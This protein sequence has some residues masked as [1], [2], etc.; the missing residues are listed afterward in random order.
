MLLEA[1]QLARRGGSDAVQ[2]KEVA[3]RAGVA[4][5]TLYRHFPS[6]KELLVA[7][8]QERNERMMDRVRSGPPVG[9]TPG[10]RVAHVLEAEF[11]GI[12]RQHKLVEAMLEAFN[13]ADRS[14]GGIVSANRRLRE[15]IMIHAATGG[16]GELTR[17]QLLVL[18]TILGAWSFDITA[19]MAGLR[20]GDD[21]LEQMQTACRML[22]LAGELDGARS[23]GTL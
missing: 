19:W 4:L 17:T 12:E 9:D 3:D 6:K 15:E 1:E 22:N 20:S 23:T 11:R 14:M 21:V 10:D 2:M 13:T 5:A 8:Y 18:R 7:L 16:T